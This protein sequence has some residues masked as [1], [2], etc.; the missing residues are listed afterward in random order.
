MAEEPRAGITLKPATTR[1][2]V[3]GLLTSLR[4]VSARNPTMVAGIAVVLAML[5]IAICAPLIASSD[6][7]DVDPFNRFAEPQSEFW[8]G[9]D[10]LGRDVF[11]RTIFGT[12]ISLTVGLSVALVSL[13]NA[14][15]I[16]LPAGYYPKLDTVIMRLMDGLMS[17]PSV[18]LAMAM[19]ALLGGS[20]QNV[21]IA[22]TV[23][24]TPRAVRVVRSSVLSL[25]E[26]MFVDAA[27]AV[28]VPP[29]R[30]LARYI[31]PNTMA[32]LIIQATFICAAAIL[33]EAYLSFLGAGPPPEI[34]S[35]GNV[36][37]EGRNFISRAVW[38][39][40]FPG[41]FLTITVLGVN[42]AGDGLRDSLDPKLR[43]RM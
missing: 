21:I 34:P 8:F 32:P 16:G 42:L 43:R 41:L 33:T 40:F 13:I 5:L 24:E 29:V 18:L 17:I 11:S 3:G 36:M 23:V 9:T 38:V 1:E 25:R 19:M 6:A 2:V 37:A 14:I 22:L 28:G 10:N 30:I 26:Q 15:L 39:I 27:R 4:K 7:G 35:W 20:M 12:R 31:L